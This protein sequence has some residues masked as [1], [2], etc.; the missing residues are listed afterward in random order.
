M[1]PV[2]FVNTF[3]ATGLTMC[4]LDF[5]WVGYVAKGFYARQLGDLLRPEA[6]WI[7]IALFYVLYISAVVVF[8]VKPA[9]GRKSFRRAIGLGAFF[10]L[11]A[12]ATYDL[13]SLALIR[14]FP[15]TAAIVDLAWGMTVTTV[16]SGVG[17]LDRKS[18]V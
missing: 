12:Y 14:D 16:A 10:G 8:V 5:V 9:A 7:P 3:I 4:A 1:N 18:V 11:V 2:R 15:L 6:R 17:Y 13:T